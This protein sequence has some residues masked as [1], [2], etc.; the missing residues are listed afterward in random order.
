VNKWAAS[1]TKWRF[2]SILKWECCPLPR[3]I[4]RIRRGSVWR[5]NS[6]FIIH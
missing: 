1:S 3:M 5:N 4:L 6:I 2:F